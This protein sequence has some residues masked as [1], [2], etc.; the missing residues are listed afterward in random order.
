MRI[1]IFILFLIGGVSCSTPMIE[2]LPN[3]YVIEVKDC[4][5]VWTVIEVEG[6]Y[7]FRIIGNWWVYKCY[8]I[9]KDEYLFTNGGE[10]LKHTYDEMINLIKIC[11]VK[12]VA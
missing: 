9:N 2:T 5:N 8:E 6:Y 7:E 1:F 12:R 10:N 4:N 11:K 3:D